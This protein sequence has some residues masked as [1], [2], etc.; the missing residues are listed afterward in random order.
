[1]KVEAPQ[2]PN[3]SPTCRSGY[4]FHLTGIPED[5]GTEQCHLKREIKEEEVESMTDIVWQEH[6]DQ[7]FHKPIH[8]LWTKHDQVGVSVKGKS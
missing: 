6:Y 8:K 5:I 1:M 2:T 3:V 7:D 4:C